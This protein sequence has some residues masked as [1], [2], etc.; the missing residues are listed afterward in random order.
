MSLVQLLARWSCCRRNI[1]KMTLERHGR[2]DTE[3]KHAEKGVPWLLVIILASCN[4]IQLGVREKNCT[5]T[6]TTESLK[7]GH[8]RRLDGA[9]THTGGGATDTPRGH[10]MGSDAIGHITAC[11]WRR[12]NF[13]A[14]RRRNAQLRRALGTCT[15][16]LRGKPNAGSGKALR[17]RAEVALIGLSNCTRAVAPSVDG[18]WKS[19]FMCLG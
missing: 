17:N 18:A 1:L 14:V 4:L 6:Q 11:E 19:S 8:F 16:R 10:S 2:M 5:A 13:D 12:G 15:L 7:G 9:A 3:A